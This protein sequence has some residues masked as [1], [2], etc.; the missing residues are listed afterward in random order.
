MQNP[1]GGECHVPSTFAAVLTAR[2]SA[3]RRGGPLVKIGA[4]VNT[5]ELITQLKTELDSL[6]ARLIIDDEMM[7]HLHEIYFIWFSS[8]YDPDNEA[9]R[10]WGQKL[11]PHITALNDKIKFKR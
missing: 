3:S 9:H 5:D 2:H 8:W 11:G 4:T 1:L 10:V 7:K 6:K